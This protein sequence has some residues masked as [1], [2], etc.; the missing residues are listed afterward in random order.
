MNLP[1]IINESSLTYEQPSRAIFLKSRRFEDI[2]YDTERYVWNIY[3]GIIWGISDTSSE[4]MY[5]VLHASLMPDSVA[6]Y[7]NI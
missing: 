1:S 2:K 4:A 7:V 3:W 6:D 5:V